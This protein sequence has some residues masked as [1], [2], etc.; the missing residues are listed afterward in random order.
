M[1]T[2]IEPSAA[3][4]YGFV[5][6]RQQ[7]NPSLPR[8]YYQ[9]SVVL[10]TAYPF[11][12][13][14]HQVIDAIALAYFDVGE[15]AIE[16]ACHHIDHWPRPTPGETL[17]MKLLDRTIICRH[18]DATPTTTVVIPSVHEVEFYRNLKSVVAHLQQLWE[19]VLLAEPLVVIAPTPAICSGIV[20]S[21]VS[22]IWPLKF[23]GEWRPFF[24]IHD[25]DFS[26]IASSPKPTKSIVLGVTNPFFSKTFG[27]WPHI[28]RVGDA[29]GGQVASAGKHYKKSSGNKT[30]D[31]NPGM[32]SQYRT[33]LHH[34]KSLM[35]KLL[36][37]GDRPDAVQ[38][39]ILR[40]HFMELTESFLI[41]LERYLATLLPL[42]KQITPFKAVPQSKPF[43][44]EDF[45]ASLRQTGP[46]LA[47]GVKGDWEGLYKRFL[48]S[49]N[50]E[51]WRQKRQ[52]DVDKQLRATHLD[53]LCTA[54]LSRDVLSTRQ[55]VEV[56]DLVLK[57]RDRLASLDEHQMEKRTR[58]QKQLH[59]VLK[60]VD[61]ELKS[62]LLSNCGLR[63]AADAVV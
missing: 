33:Y 53:V 39:T 15:P 2:A 1:P 14:Y 27:E 57:L 62:V 59:Q 10:L 19:L 63:E 36:K 6:F 38:N 28:L 46:V 60:S 49:P 41:P 18:V 34:D 4:L 26:E 21:L 13:L 30:L 22:L 11:V 52:T 61:D 3:Y 44:V 45:L 48:S 5:H 32:Y 20:T 7:R 16:A 56:V 54:E 25:S 51:G 12:A 17:K 42:R 50:F 37:V 58:L 23:C 8:G 43:V 35:K 9:K 31:L 55:E 29:N 47:S 24:T 40:R